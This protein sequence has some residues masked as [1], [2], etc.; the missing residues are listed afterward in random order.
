MKHLK[1]FENKNNT[2]CLFAYTS[3]EDSN[4]NYFEIFNDEESAKNFAIAVANEIN[5]LKTYDELSEKVY[6][7]DRN[8]YNIGDYVL[9]SGQLYVEESDKP[10]KII[11]ELHFKKSGYYKIMF[12]SG[13]VGVTQ[14]TE[15]KRYLTP[16]EIEEFDIKLNTKKYNL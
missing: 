16:E 12:N 10:V 4:S 9:I 11:R 8:K 3:Y 13:E 2:L 1:Q 5:G 6:N 7:E 15:I 14:Y